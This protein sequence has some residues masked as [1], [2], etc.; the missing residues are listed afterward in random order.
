LAQRCGRPAAVG[1]AA[2]DSLVTGGLIKPSGDGT[3]NS[4]RKY[5]L[6]PPTHSASSSRERE[7]VYI[8]RESRESHESSPMYL[9]S[10]PEHSPESRESRE[11]RDG[12]LDYAREVLGDA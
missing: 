10:N 7:R 12:L 9:P 11:S 8:T 6:V 1:R 4:P 3:K 2:V 5:S